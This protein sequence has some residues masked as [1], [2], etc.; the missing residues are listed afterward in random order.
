MV[1]LPLHSPLLARRQFLLRTATLAS[2]KPV[3]ELDSQTL[4]SFPKMLLDLFLRVVGRKIPFRRTF[5]AG[6]ADKS[7][8]TRYSC[9]SN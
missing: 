1:G 9:R 5:A 8:G 2:T 6:R 4:L 7:G 3:L